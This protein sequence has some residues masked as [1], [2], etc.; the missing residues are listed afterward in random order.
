[1]GNFILIAVII[2]L[3]FYVS[4]RIAEVQIVERK[5]DVEYSSLTSASIHTNYRYFSVIFF[6][7]SWFFLNLSGIHTLLNWIN[8]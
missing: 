8:S 3:Y 1:M 7:V 4:K 6:R 2:N 5:R